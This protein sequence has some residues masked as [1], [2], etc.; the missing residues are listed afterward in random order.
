VWDAAVNTVA[1]D[2]IMIIIGHLLLLENAQVRIRQ[3]GSA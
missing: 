1:A 2:I 3:F